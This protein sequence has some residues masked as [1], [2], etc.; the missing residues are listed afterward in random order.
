M[1]LPGKNRTIGLLMVVS[2]LLL[3]GFAIYWLA[4]QYMK[5]KQVL[6]GDLK[7]KYNISYRTTVDSFLVKHYIEPVLGDMHY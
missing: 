4:G 5:E 3:T 7:A 2:Q 6:W 1:V